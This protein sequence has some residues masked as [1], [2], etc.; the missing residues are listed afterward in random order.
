MD[1]PDYKSVE[2]SVPCNTK[3][4][5][6]TINFNPSIIRIAN[7]TFLMS[8]HVFRRGQHGHP[9]D[10]QPQP[11]IYD[12]YHMWYGGPESKTWWNEDYD[13]I[14]GTGYMIIKIFNREVVIHQI[15]D[16]IGMGY[17]TRLRNTP[18]GI[19]ATSS[20][21]SFF[22][23][24][25]IW[26]MDRVKYGLPPPTCKYQCLAIY[27]LKLKLTYASHIDTYYLSNNV[28]DEGEPLCPRLQ[29]Q[30]K[31]WS[32]FVVNNK[33][34]TSQWLTPKHTVIPLQYP[35]CQIVKEPNINVFHKIETFY[36]GAVKFSLSTPT[37]QFGP[38]EM[39]GVGHVKLFGDY[40]PIGTNAYNFY[41]E[42]ILTKDAFNGIYMMFFYTF[43]PNTFEILRVSSAFYPPN[44]THGIV[45][46]AGLT[47]FDD[48]YI[49]SYGEGDI[50][51]KLFFVSP[52]IINQILYKQNDMYD[53]YIFIYNL[54][55]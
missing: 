6:N 48:D 34:Y 36:K 19:M 8:F 17:D 52:T 40:L 32:L 29:D 50:K 9:C 22:N 43:D 25:N 4:F 10:I 3:I 39:I 21:N 20:L 33:M 49:I 37:L 18:V 16:K 12:E 44:T 27:Y 26:G 38:S 45:F 7:D 42:N 47:F 15:F 1:I 23:Y 46:A 51:M 54:F 55:D 11:S 31:N 13:G 30:E 5:G 41:I 24:K 35:A 28:E 53:D 2:I 14:R